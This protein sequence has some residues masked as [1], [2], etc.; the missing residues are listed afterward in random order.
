MIILR[1]P[2]QFWQL[3]ANG[4]IAFTSWPKYNIND[5]NVFKYL[6]WGIL[7]FSCCCT[8]GAPT[9]YSQSWKFSKSLGNMEPI[10]CKKN[11][12]K[13]LHI[14]LHWTYFL[15]HHHCVIVICDQHLLH[16]LILKYLLLPSHYTLLAFLLWCRGTLISREQ[17]YKS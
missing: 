14:F 1:P 10:T 2:L 7:T 6:K 17:R 11:Q 3:V 13:N 9:L 12:T 15:L 8:L 5:W 4:F 16:L